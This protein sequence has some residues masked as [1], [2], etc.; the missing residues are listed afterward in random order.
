MSSEIARE[1]ARRTV[2]LQLSTSRRGQSVNFV[3]A[4]NRASVR[5]SFIALLV[6]SATFVYTPDRARDSLQG[7]R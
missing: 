5:V 4:T 2:I 1:Q 3:C 7:R 6:A